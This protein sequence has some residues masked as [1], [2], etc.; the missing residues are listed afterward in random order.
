MDNN[1]LFTSESVTEGHPDKVCD[2]ISDSILDNILSQDPDARVACETLV[3]QGKVVV[4]GEITTSAIVDYENIIDNTLSKIGYNK[5]DLDY[6]GL[7]YKIATII[8][9]QSPHIAQG[10]N[11][12]NQHEQGAGDQ[13]LM[14]GYAC[15]ETPEFMP[16]PIVLAHCLTKKMSEVRKNGT[17]AWLKPDGK[18]QVTIQYSA[19]HKPIK[20]KKIVIATQHE[21]MLNKFD[22]E[23][24]E[25]TF[26]KDNVIKHIIMPVLNQYGLE[27]DDEFI[28]NGTGRF[29]EG[30]PIADVGL[31][32][33]KIIVDT[34]GGYSRHGGG[35]FSGK[36]ASKVDR[37]AA[38]MARYIAKNIVAADI[39]QKC[40]VQLAYCIG[41]AKPMSVNINTFNSSLYDDST[42]IDLIKKTF[43]L[44][45]ASIVDTLDLK[46]PTYSRFA[47]YGHFGREINCTWE[48]IDMVDILKEKITVGELS[49]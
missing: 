6:N 49:K 27:Y 41:V 25:H 9:E 40:E 34:Y 21:D 10:V 11:I 39:A 3:T 5:T 45:P 8:K 15:K 28:V 22:S 32:G 35:A 38:Y 36:D 48:K 4:S 46:K 37:S 44:K 33:R 18:S 20:V 14:F 23:F 1:Y 43:D 19:N 29:V 24:N 42:L 47:A 16:L 31:T 26:I 13:G 7:E 30:G 2:L 17:L 12:S